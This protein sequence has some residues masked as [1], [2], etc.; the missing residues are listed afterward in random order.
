MTKTGKTGR[1]GLSLIILMLVPVVWWLTVTNWNAEIFGLYSFRRMCLNLFITACAVSIVYILLGKKGVRHKAL[2]VL[3]AFISTG[4]CLLLLEIPALFFGFDYQKIFGTGV[5]KDALHLSTKINEP[6]HVLIHKHWPGSSFSGEVVGNLAHLGIPHPNRY[7]VDVQYD[8]NG[9]RNDREY[10]NADIA[11]IGDSFVEAAIIPLDKSLVKL[12][13]S[14]LNV[15][16]VNLGQI[17]YGFKQE[18]EVLK[19]YALPLSPKLVVWALFGG[20]DLR[21]VDAYEKDLE[22]FGQP[23]EAQPLTNRL[24][25]R[26][27]LVASSNILSTV[28]RIRPGSI[29]FDKSGLFPRNDS[30]RERVYFGQT[31][32]PW[33]DHQWDVATDTLIT[34]KHLSNEGA[35][36]FVVVYIP[37][38]YRIYRDYIEVDPTTSIAGWDVAPLP[39]ALARWC[40]EHGIEFIDTTPRLA[41]V[42]AKG[43]HPYFIDDVHWNALGH[44]IAADTIIEYLHSNKLFPFKN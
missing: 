27:L 20:N 1:W 14:R 16:T 24:F 41:E 6:D 36:D 34:A 10:Q 38:K 43:I 30:K 35:A 4:I 31:S 26:N 40:A 21:D 11:V 33:T 39:E 7:K 2:S 25:T 12:L 37:R 5:S 22:N 44:E 13:E 9:F 23:A 15:P 18:L 28:F 29:A 8:S 42:V 17:A 19:R 32:D 3:T